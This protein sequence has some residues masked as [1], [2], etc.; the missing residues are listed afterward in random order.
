MNATKT[1]ESPAGAA[2]DVLYQKDVSV[3]A[4]L[5]VA[6]SSR[7]LPPTA[8]PKP[9]NRHTTPIH[10]SRER[11]ILLSAERRK[12]VGLQNLLAD[13][14]SSVDV[15]MIADDEEN[16]VRAS[17]MKVTTQGPSLEQKVKEC[18]INLNIVE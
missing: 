11:N 18:S 7:M 16:S 17:G 3:S 12:E 8:I 10:W 13:G 14:V 9:L 6:P 15:N 2:E 1:S 5:E 4:E